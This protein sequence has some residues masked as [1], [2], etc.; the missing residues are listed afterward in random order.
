MSVEQIIAVVGGLI[1]ATLA[2]AIF[3]L[4]AHDTPRRISVAIIVWSNWFFAA[5]ALGLLVVFWNAWSA[6]VCGI[7]IFVALWFAFGGFIVRKKYR[8]P[9]PPKSEKN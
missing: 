9:R 1:G 7:A 3:D 2:M 8:R 4:N 5:L 6:D